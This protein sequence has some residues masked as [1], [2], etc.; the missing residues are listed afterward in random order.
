MR[1]DPDARYAS[2]AEM[3]A[4]IR[5]Y[6]TGFPVLAHPGSTRYRAGKFVG[7][8]PAL[9]PAILLAVALLVGYIVTLTRHNAELARER[10][11]ASEALA[12]ATE[13]RD[14]FVDLFR[15]ADPY[16]P[17][18]AARGRNIT[19]VEALNLGRTKL[20]ADLA[21]RPELRAALLAAV[22]EV[23]LNL[24]QAAEAVETL[25]RAVSV[26]TAM[27]DTTS[28]K[29][30][31]NLGTLGTAH[32]AL[33]ESELAGQLFERELR[34]ART[35]S[36]PD[37]GR[38]SAALRMSALVKAGRDPNA[39]VPL[40]LEAVAV[41]RAGGGEMLAEALRKLADSLRS[42]GDLPA[43]EAAAR[44]ALALFRTMEG[45]S[46]I[47]T[48][49]AVHSL[50]QALAV[51]G[52]FEE[53][54]P[55][56]DWSLAIL[57]RRL[58]RQHDM[59]MAMR[60]NLGLFYVVTRR[61]PEAEAMLRQLLNDR[62]ARF[63]EQSVQAATSHQNLAALLIRQGRLDEADAEA[64]TAA[65]IYGG[66]TAGGVYNVAF[67][68]LTRAEIALA[69]EDFGTGLDY[70]RR[71][72][73]LL[74]GKLS[75]DH[76]AVIMADCRMGRVEAGLG[77]PSAARQHLESAVARLERLA[78]S[79]EGHLAECRDALAALGAG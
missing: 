72:A 34:L 48:G 24:D 70:A 38:L 61:W 6:L 3:S 78:S 45:D 5:R 28:G 13:T 42:V 10:D 60:N 16:A 36:S 63:G 37:S 15:A 2:L 73:A 12:L 44:E 29:F 65:R 1:A 46:T 23:L 62:I 43:S 52:Q 76:P 33:G 51:R 59:T 67:P 47:R 4:D 35:M 11:A 8:H 30:Q 31:R 27:G 22:G 64:A 74:R 9:L 79:S 25:D 56:L 58:G 57:D 77:Q 14:F 75:D 49:F 7:R 54:G 19:V 55:L 39:A 53:A 41:A 26:R 68:L 71:A 50:G 20:E 40:N 21:D 69:H 66:P 17:A 18:D 32:L